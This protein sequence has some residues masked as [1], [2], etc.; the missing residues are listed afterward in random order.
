[1]VV[2]EDD[3]EE[4]KFWLN[5]VTLLSSLY[6]H[7]SPIFH[8]FFGPQLFWESLVSNVDLPHSWVRCLAPCSHIER[9]SELGWDGT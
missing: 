7:L 8:S 3:S 2:R 6:S 9:M 5:A 1:M 4:L